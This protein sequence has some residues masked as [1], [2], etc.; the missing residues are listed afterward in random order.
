[1]DFIPLQIWAKG[2]IT[3]GKWMLSISVLLLLLIILAL[4]S[5]DTLFHGMVIPISL[6]LILN[7]GYGIY[8]VTNRIRYAERINRQ[9]K[10]EAQKTVIREY[11]K[12]KNEKK[13]YVTVRIIWAVL[14]VTS[15]VFYCVFT[16]DYGRG[17]SL[18]CLRLFF[19]LL[20]IDTFLHYRLLIYFVNLKSSLTIE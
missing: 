18:G 20:C 16:T 14:I 1:M 4:R 7:T 17:L 3:Q 15:L 9:F 12:V 5:E 8:L 6:L 13:T 10:K 19:G 11:T 2:E